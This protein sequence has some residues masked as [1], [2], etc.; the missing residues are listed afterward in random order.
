MESQDNEEIWE[1]AVA[2]AA[3]ATPYIAAERRVAPDRLA[4]LLSLPRLER[5]RAITLER[6]F[7]TYSLAAYAL[8]K[9]ERAISHNPR[10]ALGL[11]RL[12]R[13]ITLQIDPRTCGGS[14]A[15]F[16]LGAYALASEGNVERVCGNLAAALEIFRRVREVQTRGCADPDLTFRIDLL[17]SSLRRDL[18]HLHIALDLVERAAEGFLVLGEHERWIRAQINRSNVFQVQEE[19]EEAALILDDISHQTNDPQSTLCIR[20]NLAYLLARS[21][22]PFEAVHLIEKSQGLYRSF[23]NPLITSRRLW[24]EGLI[25]SGLGKDELAE[26]LLNRAETELGKRGFVF[27]AALA[28]LDFCKLKFRREA[29]PV[30]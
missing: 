10:F 7:Q 26:G 8:E 1:R 23:S 28:Q 20:H 18:G 22:R 16:D 4:E 15:L 19:F 17:E 21:G 5:A 13:A 27:D 11:T 9:S 29:E 6:R 3:A 24:V 30:C 25:A 12:A 2:Q 14:A